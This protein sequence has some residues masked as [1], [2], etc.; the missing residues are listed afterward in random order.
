MLKHR[1]PLVKALLSYGLAMRGE[2]IEKTSL[3]TLK[4]LLY[5]SFLL[6]SC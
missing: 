4:K 2:C 1:F 3:E 6:K 5:V